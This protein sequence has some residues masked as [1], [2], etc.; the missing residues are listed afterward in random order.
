MTEVNAA[1]ARVMVW[2]PDWAQALLILLAALMTGWI[3]HRMVYGVLG[4]LA[5]GRSLFWRSLHSRSRKPAR[6][7]FLMLALALGASVAPITV[8]QASTLRHLLMIAFIVLIAW[9]ARMALSIWTV[10]YL[11]RFTLDSEDNLAARK[12]VTQTRILQRI[13]NM[14]I[15]ILGVGT[16]LMTFDAVRQYGVSLL[17]SAGAAGIVA[18]LALQ[19]LLKNVFA[20][21]QLAI[22][23]PIRIDDALL[24]EGEW[25]NVEEITS[26]YVVVRIW[27]WRRLIVPLS[28]FIEQP[29]QNWTRESAQLIGTVMLYLDHKAPVGRIRDQ[30]EAIAKASP[31]W[32]GKVFNL[33]VTDFKE[34]VMEVRVL[35]SARNSGRAFDLRCEM[36]EK[37]IDWIQTEIPEALP[38][39]RESLDLAE[40]HPALAASGAPIGPMAGPDPR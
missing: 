11:R 2:V 23:Q 18:G 33:A 1:L 39:T 28:Y 31:L 20:G 14:L 15:L 22:T 25:G 35:V 3:V 30:A 17:A 38:R 40:A 4:R 16:A 6:L 24:I 37:L 8:G 36:R 13:A 34:R 19:P 27:D 10:I 9:I 21:I 7:A 29:F 12:H 5:E 26:T 32:D